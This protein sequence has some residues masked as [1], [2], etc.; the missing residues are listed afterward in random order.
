MDACVPTLVLQPNMPSSKLHSPW[1]FVGVASPKTG[2][3]PDATAN[4]GSPRTASRTTASFIFSS[5]WPGTHGELR[6]RNNDAECR[7]CELSLCRVGRVTADL[8]TL[9]RKQREKRG[10]P[11]SRQSGLRWQKPDESAIRVELSQRTD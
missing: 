10:S 8:C 3:C 7:C 5:R 4:K 9:A 1:E 6:V 11:R 2:S